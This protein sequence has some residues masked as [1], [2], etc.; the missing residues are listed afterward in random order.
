MW[1]PSATIDLLK[2]RSEILAT[3]REFFR[4]R[5]V[6][7][8]D[9]PLL[10]HASVTDP[11][12]YSMA[13]LAKKNKL[14]YLQT[15]P[16]YAMK[17]LLAAGSGS[18]YQICKAFRQEES[19]RFHNPEFTMLE[20][21]RVDFDHHALMDEVD[22][23]LQ[24]ILNT[25]KADK[26]SYEKLFIQYLNLNPN[27]ATLAEINSCITKHQLKIQVSITNKDTGLQLLL[28]HLIEPKLGLEK[29][30]FIYDFPPTQAALARITEK[31]LA[32]R[33]EL[34]FKGIELANGF[35]E[36]TNAKE[37]RKRFENDLMKRKKLKLPELNIDTY[38]LNALESGLPPC[39]GVAVGI[40]RIIMLATKEDHINK[41]L[42]FDFERA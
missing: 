41:V 40:D 19:G 25:S 14:M 18:I 17:R 16:E 7:E 3:I 35:H 34:Y 27:L 23:L 4:L 5:G 28:S 12:I 1:Q 38:F 32:A 30:I 13:V 6:L 15:S 37:Q 29:P 8:V 10:C 42:S 31:N 20:W 33:F 11:F 39:A 26:I 24:I 21:Y 2:R 36:L 9:T 22:E